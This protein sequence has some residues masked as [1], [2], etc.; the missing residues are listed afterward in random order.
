MKFTNL[1]LIVFVAILFASCGRDPKESAGNTNAAGAANPE[2]TA[3]VYHFIC[4][5][6]CQGSGAM[7]A[8]VCPV[9]GVNYIH[10]DAYHAQD[11]PGSNPSINT[12]QG[13][14]N[15]Q[16]QQNPAAPQTPQAPQA[17]EPAQN[18]AG[19]YHYTCS[20]GCSGGS[21]TGGTCATC[22]G[23]LTHNQAYH[24]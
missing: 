19:V 6:N 2:A 20:K 24:Q 13:P 17:P 18:A 4:R 1:L 21:G 22:G 14:Q 12:L 10:N 3:V 9:C 15:P 7:E 5:N 16:F 11:V 8:G 23:P